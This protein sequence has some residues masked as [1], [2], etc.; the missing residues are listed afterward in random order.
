MADL[1][2][3]KPPYPMSGI[4]MILF[5]LSNLL[6]EG[7]ADDISIEEVKSHARDGDLV[8]FLTEKSGGTF[9]MGILEMAD[10]RNFRAWYVDQ[11]VANCISMD[12]RERRKYGIENRGICLLISYTAELLQQATEKD[13]ELRAVKLP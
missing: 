9:A 12:G 1:E 8:E 6:D 5:A 13:I 11:I 10:Y 2:P 3:M 4:A 7:T